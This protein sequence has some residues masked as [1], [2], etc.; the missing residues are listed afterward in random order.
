MENLLLLTYFLIASLL[1][2]K[3]PRQGRILTAASGIVCPGELCRVVRLKLGC[4]LWFER[5]HLHWLQLWLQ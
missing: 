3:A 5:L 1:D 4:G 2:H